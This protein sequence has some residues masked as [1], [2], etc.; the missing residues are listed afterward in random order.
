M[1]KSKD[2][3]QSILVTGHAEFYRC[4]GDDGTRYYPKTNDKRVVAIDYNTIGIPPTVQGF[5]VYDTTISGDYAVAIYGDIS[6]AHAHVGAPAP[7][8]PIEI[9]EA[10]PEIEVSVEDDVFRIVEAEEPSS[11]STKRTKYKD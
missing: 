1:K 11:F 6:D 7:E 8:A 9:F 5:A 10:E 2:N 4:D 3:N